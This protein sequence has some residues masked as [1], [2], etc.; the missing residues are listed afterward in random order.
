MISITLLVEFC[1]VL[2]DSHQRLRVK[3]FHQVWTALI[4][5]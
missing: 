4:T 2:R 3:K 5:S 1:C